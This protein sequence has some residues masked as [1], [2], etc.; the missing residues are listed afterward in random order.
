MKKFETQVSTNAM[1][2]LLLLVGSAMMSEKSQMLLARDMVKEIGYPSC[3]NVDVKGYLKELF[4]LVTRFF[5]E[6][7]EDGK[8]TAQA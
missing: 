1:S 8:D 6:C 4:A 5:A 3:S 2:V 7:N